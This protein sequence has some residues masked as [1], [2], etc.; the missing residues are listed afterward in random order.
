MSNTEDNINEG[1]V[2]MSQILAELDTLRERVEAFT[3][4]QKEVA[5]VASAEVAE[6][7]SGSDHPAD[8]NDSEAGLAS[9]REQINVLQS[10]RKQERAQIVAKEEEVTEQK[11]ENK[12]LTKLIAN[13]SGELK[14]REVLADGLKADITR[15]K[16]EVE[17]MATRHEAIADLEKTLSE[18]RSNAS[19]SDSRIAEL[20]RDEVLNQ[21]LSEVIWPSFLLVPEFETWKKSLS[22]GLFVEP[23]SPVVANVFTSLASYNSFRR[24]GDPGNKR[25]ID[26]VHDLGTALFNWFAESRLDRDTAYNN[27]TLWAEAIN[28]ENAEVLTISVP[29]PDTP[30][31]RR[32]M[33]N[34]SS[35][36]RASRDVGEATGWCLTDA[37]G[38]IQKQATVNTI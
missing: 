19:Q 6:K 8:S 17:G 12:R 22:D 26:S 18:A 25:L 4:S 1:A 29:E 32:T 10:E 3:N 23:L 28:R 37:E 35:S 14:E 15:L 36:G 33:V 5:R 30:F 21:K 38:R 13:F 2:E 20:E 16:T 24:I 34:Y 9:L 7:Q 27:A 11:E 31:D